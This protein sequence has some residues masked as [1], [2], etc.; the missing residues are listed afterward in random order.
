MKIL[1]INVL[2]RFSILLNINFFQESTNTQ[3]TKSLKQFPFAAQTAS[4]TSPPSASEAE[5]EINATIIENNENIILNLTDHNDHVLA[6]SKIE[7]MSGK[8][9]KSSSEIISLRNID[10]S[11]IQSNTKDISDSDNIVTGNRK[12]ST[13]PPV[14]S[15]PPVLR[16]TLPNIFSNAGGNGGNLD[17]IQ[18]L[19]SNGNIKKRH[20][21]RRQERNRKMTR[22]ANSKE[23]YQARVARLRHELLRAS[24]S[25][26][27]RLVKSKPLRKR[28]KKRNSGLPLVEALPVEHKYAMNPSQATHHRITRAA[29]AKKDRIWDYGVIPYEIDGNFSG[30]HKALFKQAMKHWEKYSGYSCLFYLSNFSILSASRALNL[31]REMS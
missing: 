30:G 5:P 28:S 26:P 16:S 22:A 9:N 3:G 4:S 6:S 18:I 20:R 2:H 24:E 12:A 1:K 17:D 23:Q 19:N 27:E 7:Y 21:K 8:S 15:A 14:T 13:S 10:S 31:S 11:K 29:T 25:P